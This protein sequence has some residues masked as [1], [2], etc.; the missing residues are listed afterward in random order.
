MSPNSF[1]LHLGS[2]EEFAVARNFF[3]GAEFND[4]TLCRV[5]ELEDMSDL[6]R[7][8]WDD[9][10]LDTL[11]ASL[12]WCLH[13]FVRGLSADETESRVVCGDQVFVALQTL[14]L[15]RATRK[16]PAAVVCPVWLYPVD[17]FVVVTDRR[18]DPEGEAFAPPEDIVFP[19]IYAGTLRFLRLL[20][21]AR[22][23]DALDLCGGSGIGAL[24]LARTAR[25]VI[26][27]DLTERS[28]FFAEFNARLN[29]V[30]VQSVCG[31]L[32]APVSGRQFDLITAHPP[33]VPASGS[34]M[35]YRDGGETGEEVTRR[36]IEALPAHLRLGG[37]C[38]ILCVARDTQEQALEHRVRDWLGAA[39]DEFDIVFGLEKV[40]SVDEVV[41]SLRKR[42]QQISEAEAK[43]LSVR[44]RS[45]GTRQ[46]VY[47]AVI[48]HRCSEPVAPKPFRIGLT[49]KGGAADFSRLLA[50]RHHA[51]QPGFAG[52]LH[53]SRPR[54]APRLQ[55]TARHVVLAGELVP[56]EFV[57]AIEDGLEAALRPDAW[58]VPL[59]A[60]LNG[61]RSVAE[62]FASASQADEL[63]KGF[64]LEDFAGLVGNMI[65]RGFLQ[66]ELPR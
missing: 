62:V 32:Y 34:N 52:W 21:E 56:A 17:G 59:L 53:Q 27:A 48:I 63:P 10:K 38:V 24:H 3:E 33:F 45:L 1:P 42:G 5:L 65:E 64:R 50:W 58:V 47:G 54:F 49:S 61:N 4:A 19:A 28:A 15:I 18:E 9:A 41:D 35:V 22:D 14:G 7:V 44:L 29:G 30:E 55:L 8:R 12:R 43:D 11:A 37:L 40:L 31:D 51:R 26:T 36:T 6:G 57:F 66:V 13:V 23:G 60:Q 20:P 46:F 39:R 25:A 2:S 16:K